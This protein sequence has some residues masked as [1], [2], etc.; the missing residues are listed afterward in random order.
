[1]CSLFSVLLQLQDVGLFEDGK[2]LTEWEVPVAAF[3]TA[4]IVQRHQIT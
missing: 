1:M 2:V 4:R 3:G